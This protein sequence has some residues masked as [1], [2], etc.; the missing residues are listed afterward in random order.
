MSKRKSTAKVKPFDFFAILIYIVFFPICMISK[1]F[2][3]DLWIISERGNDAQDNGYWFFKY[4]RDTQ[5][6][7]NAIY[8]ISKK[9]KDYEKIRKMGKVVEPKS[10]MHWF[11]YLVATKSISAHKGTKP[12]AAVFY[13]I[14]VIF[15]IKTCQIIFLQHGITKDLPTWLLYDNTNFDLFI[16]G[17]KPEYEFI[18]QNFGYPERNVVYTGLARF[19]NLFNCDTDSDQILIIPTWR[20]W[21]NDV[22][23]E[24]FLN[25]EF[26]Q[27]WNSFISNQKLNEY[28]ISNNKKILFYVHPNIQ[29]FSSLFKNDCNNIEIIPQNKFTISYLLK[30]CSLMITDYS[31]VFFDFAYMKKPV[32]F[33][34]FD[35]NKYRENQYDEGY[36]DYRNNPIGK[37][38]SCETELIEYFIQ[39]TG[40]DFK[41]SLSD[42]E[43]ISDFFPLYDNKNCER[44]FNEIIKRG[45]SC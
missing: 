43:S 37:S 1:I 38:V 6:H 23:E 9:S 26:F 21:L 14:E 34:Q 11:Y 2:I 42:K 15:K 28:I 4:L 17:A 19:D 44:I 5:T 41:I 22:S 10:I 36:F 31:S 30:K 33:Y 32:I 35:Y 3:K 13:L 7:V 8:V 18:N 45:K 25:S 29:K 39:T 27:K 24:V 20:T 12:N 16:C 40:N